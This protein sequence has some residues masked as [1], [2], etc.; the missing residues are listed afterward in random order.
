MHRLVL[1]WTLL[2]AASGWF[3]G[4]MRADPAPGPKTPTAEV[5]QLLDQARG[6]YES[7]RYQEAVAILRDADRE[8][9]GSCVACLELLAD[10]FDRLGAHKNMADAARRLLALSPGEEVLVRAY[11][12][13]GQALL[14]RGEK[15]PESLPEA[16]ASFRKALDLTHGHSSVAQF[17]LG[18][19]LIR[20]GQK[21]PGLEALRQFA[22]LDPRA[23]Q[24]GL[25]RQYIA[26]PSCVVESCVPD[27]ALV[28]RDGGL[29]T[30]EEYAGSVVVLYFW[31]SWSEQSVRTLAE[32][33]RIARRAKDE[34]AHFVAIGEDADKQVFA[35]IDVAAYPALVLT[36]DDTSALA[37]QLAI[38]S[39][40]TTLVV[41]PRGRIVHR[42][43]GWDDKVR[44]DLLQV[45]TRAAEDARKKTH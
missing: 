17:K 37:R 7:R 1:S 39:Y 34:P 21:E 10:T 35:G 14:S 18:V 27:F 24:A 9:G 42:F 31:G 12:R 38:E 13:L 33:D 26:D 19:T 28:T 15:E 22:K 32:I 36:R 25:A 20:M 4:E 40:P 11:E 44:A 30:P 45:V 16:A 8:S 43:A 29:A 6:L 5:Q 41:N 23:P 2:F 3:A